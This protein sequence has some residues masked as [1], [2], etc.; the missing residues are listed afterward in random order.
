MRNLRSELTIVNSLG[1]GAA[2]VFVASIIES[3]SVLRPENVTSIFLILLNSVLFRRAYAVEYDF[4]LV[5]HQSEVS[6]EESDKAPRRLFRP[7]RYRP[8]RGCVIFYV[9]DGPQQIMPVDNNRHSSIFRRKSY[10]T[11]DNCL[12][13]PALDQPAVIGAISALR[14]EFIHVDFIFGVRVDN[15]YVGLFAFGHSSLI[16]AD[17]FCGSFGH[18]SDQPRPVDNSRLNQR[19]DVKRQ[20]TFEPGYAERRR[21]KLQLL[22]ALQMRGMVGNKCINQ[23]VGYRLFQRLDVLFG[24]QRRIDLIVG[25]VFGTAFLRSAAND[26][27]L[28]R[29]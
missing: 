20:R 25:V 4:C 1:G 14:A 13:D 6:V 24:P 19:L 15:G 8:L 9:L 29:R 26:A 2:P 18:Q 16:D 21:Q 27:A 22:F 3:Q 23:P 11:A 7:W 5:A 10:F 17:Y 12:F 28:P